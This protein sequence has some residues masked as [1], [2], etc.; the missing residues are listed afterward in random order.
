MKKILIKTLHTTNFNGGL[1]LLRAAALPLLVFHGWPKLMQFFSDEPIRFM[2]VMGMSA[3]LSLALAMFAELVCS[4][5][6]LLGLFTRLAVIPII[7]TMLTI[8]LH[9]HA[10]DPFTRKELPLMYAIIFTFILIAGA[11]N[12]SIDRLIHNRIRGK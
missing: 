4:L 8:I 6:V 11:G 7:F 3:T 1:L 9:V 10:N 5:L 12:F 2:S